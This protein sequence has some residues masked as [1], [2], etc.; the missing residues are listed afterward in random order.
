MHPYCKSY[1]ISVFFFLGTT[2]PSGPGP[3][4]YPAFTLTLS[5]T[6]H[7]AGLLRARD[8][9]HAETYIHKTNIHVPSG[10]RARNP[11]KLAATDPR[12]RRA[13]PPASAQSTFT[14]PSYWQ[15]KTRLYLMILSQV[16][17]TRTVSVYV[18]LFPQLQTVYPP[19]WDSKDCH[20]RNETGSSP[21]SFGL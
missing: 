2:V 4:K 16:C 6:P 3:P 10:I 14:S 1:K 13:R 17:R 11:S 5:L 21:D 20:H 15:R 18:A 19:E 7:S 9:P 8:Q 12:L